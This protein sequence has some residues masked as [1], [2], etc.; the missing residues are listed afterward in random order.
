MDS[1]TKEKGAQ[2]LSYAPLHLGQMPQSKP[3]VFPYLHDTPALLVV[4]RH[5]FSVPNLIRLI[6]LK[7][8]PDLHLHIWS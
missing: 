8:A 5:P 7:K 3:R 6:T 2:E 4:I 1:I